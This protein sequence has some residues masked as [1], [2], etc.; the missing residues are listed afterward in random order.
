MK[1]AH[2]FFLIIVA[3]SL[4]PL[5]LTS[6]WLFQ[7]QKMAQR[8]SL[9][10]HLGVAQFSSEAITKY[11]QGLNRRVGFMLDLERARA[12]GRNQQMLVIQ[13]AMATNADFAFL[14]VVDSQGREIV[15]EYNADIYKQAQDYQARSGEE[16]FKKAQKDRRVSLGEIV[17]LEGRPMMPLVYPFHY[18]GYGYLMVDLHSVFQNLTGRTLGTTGH[19]IVINK[20]GRPLAPFA[21]TVSRL[22]VDSLKELIAQDDVGISDYIPSEEGVMVGAFQRVTDMPWAVLT[23]QSREDAFLAAEQLTWTIIGWIGLVALVAFGVAYVTALRVAGPIERLNAGALRVAQKDLSK[24]VPE[25]GWGELKALARSFNQMMQELQAFHDLQVGKIVEEK[26]R[27]ETLVYSIPDGIVMADF[28]GQVLYVN[29]PA[30][31]MLGYQAPAAEPGS[32]DIYNVVQEARIRPMLQRVMRRAARKDQMEISI[33]DKAS[34]R[35]RHFAAAV[36]TVA[37]A[38]KADLGILLLMRDVSV[39]RELEEMKEQF[40][41]SLA[42]DLRAPITAVQGY[43][44]LLEK[45][46]PAGER[47]KRYFRSVYAGTRQVLALVSDILDSAKMKEGK[48]PLELSRIE[49][50]PM[51]RKIQELFTPVASQKG[52]RL[53]LEGVE[54]IPGV[55]EGDA[56]LIERVVTNLVSNALKFCGS[57]ARVALE[58]E[59]I[60]PQRVELAVA[61]TGPGIPPDKLQAVFERFKQL[62][63][64]EKRSGFGLGLSICKMVV[65]MHGGKIWVESVLG[66]GSRFR[67]L[68]PRKVPAKTGETAIPPAG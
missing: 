43:V 40:F 60:H 48:L 26:T 35:T 36:S 8:N 34:G 56:R 6:L 28:S 19:V 51:L 31:S 67:I 2:R 55:L 63:S 59:S 24:P 44:R 42:H 12:I 23:L 32:L 68:L 10:L 41:H 37:A 17:M 9:E 5:G 46:L 53:A 39:E 20:S 4:L 13:Q 29:K 1:L 7:F 49:V 21:D 50:V 16:V 3:A 25:V 18:G 64:G 62:E 61:D 57:G 30:L 38:G 52:I 66:K 14:S 33:N 22:P 54:K 47:E 27:V 45:S 58:F 65:E 11:I 15:K